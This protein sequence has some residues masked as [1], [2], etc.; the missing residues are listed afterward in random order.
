MAKR[1]HRLK[2]L[3]AGIVLWAC[4]QFIHAE[5]ELDCRSLDS[6]KILTITLDSLHHTHAHVVTRELIHQVG[7]KFLCADWQREKTRLE[8]LDIFAEITLHPIRLDSGID[9]HY[10][11]HELPSYIP[12]GTVNKTDQNGWSIGPALAALNF[13][14][15]AIRLDFMARF[16]GTTEYQMSLS[17]PWIGSYPIRYD[18]AFLVVDDTNSFEHFHERSRR[19]KLD[20][21]QEIHGPWHAVYYGEIMRMDAAQKDILLT[22]AAE[23]IPRLGGGVLWDSRSSRH[24]TARG[25]Y[26]ELRFTQNGGMLGGPADYPEWLSDSRFYFS[27][28]KRNNLIVSSLYQYR[29]GLLKQ[30][31]PLYD[32]YH[33]G[34]A[35]TLRGFA[36]NAFQG[37]SEW[38][39]TLEERY[40]IIPRKI[41]RFFGING[42]YALE[43][44]VGLDMDALW[45]ARSPLPRHFQ[46]SFFAG[47][48]LVLPGI[49]R[50]R[51]EIGSN[52]TK[53]SF[54]HD[55]GILEKTDTQR[56]RSR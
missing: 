22:G 20:L 38:L 27:W 15:E 50:L 1:V 55:I 2:P 37:P 48:H 32:L 10:E 43:G 8:D 45:E 21:I 35:N 25:F 30:T 53:L 29:P 12:F 19:I 47:L 44:L 41:F 39:N 6:L 34:G 33:V 13:W 52:T 51:I 23:Y 42:Y 31:F 14:G 3:F 18:L 46:S 54:N 56:Y 28:L 26:Q 24:N 40:A 5:N 9:L 4:L 49:D 16:G 17:S 7:N 11:F 36:H